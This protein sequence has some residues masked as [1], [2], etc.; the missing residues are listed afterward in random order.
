VFTD[1]PE[2]VKNEFKEKKFN[3][4]EGHTEL[5]DLVLMSQHDN[6]VCSNSTFSWWG[7]FL[8]EKKD[9][10]IVPE[11]WFADGREEGDIYRKG[12]IKLKL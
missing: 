7:S 3:L 2:Y 9:K 6:V 5:E 4:I 11:K 1:S 8:G 12:M 10:I